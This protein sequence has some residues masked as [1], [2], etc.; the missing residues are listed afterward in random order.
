MPTNTPATASMAQVSS[1]THK[2][3][4]PLP[5]HSTVSWYR[6]RAAN[7]QD[8]LSLP[9]KN[10]SIPILFICATKDAALKPEMARNM[11]K[12]I[13]DLTTHFVKAGHWALWEKPEEVN[14]FIRE[15]LAQQGLGVGGGKS[16]L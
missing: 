3:V 15:W 11:D 13:K 6:T 9:T 10:L 16:R 2:Q 12:Y 5:Y 8:E 1:R 7:F 4:S 14:R